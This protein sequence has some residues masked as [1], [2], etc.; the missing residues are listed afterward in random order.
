MILLYCMSDTADETSIPPKGVRNALIES[1]QGSGMHC[2]YS[3]YDSFEAQ[4]DT[5]R[6]DALDFHWTVNHVFQQGAVIPFRFPTLIPELST[7]EAFIEKNGNAYAADLK[8]LK[9]FVQ[10]EVRIQVSSSKDLSSGTGYLKAKQ[11]SARAIEGSVTS[12][13]GV[14][15]EVE[16]KRRAAADQVRLF[17]LVPR[18]QIDDFR[19]RVAEVSLDEMMTMRV[20]GPWPATEF[21]NC[22]PEMVSDEAV[23]SHD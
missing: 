8:R 19:N 15:P 1:Y 5:A 13:Q 14:Y 16:W 11:K 18:T 22:I 7:L 9:A 6:Q 23:R 2:F 3:L 10:M 20:S 12:I 4:A 17:A 21:I